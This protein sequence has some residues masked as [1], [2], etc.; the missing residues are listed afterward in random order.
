MYEVSRSLLKQYPDTMLARMAS[1]TWMLVGNVNDNG[2]KKRK[3][4][5]NGNNGHKNGDKDDDDKSNKKGLFIERNGDRFQFCLDYMR[6]GGIIELPQTVSKEALLQ[7]LNYYG[8]HDVDP[9]SIS[10]KG[11]LS[12]FRTGKKRI[13][14]LKKDLEKKIDDAHKMIVEADR[15]R[16]L[17]WLV[18]VMLGKYE[19]DPSLR[20]RIV[21]SD[22]KEV[23]DIAMELPGM[24]GWE[25]QSELNVH[26]EIIGLRC[27]DACNA[28]D[29]KA[30]WLFL[31]FV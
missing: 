21:E 7:D 4:N 24:R 12:M 17:H 3:K 13:L 26:L 19:R 31:E 25:K 16:K 10:V 28:N 2:S 23:Y 29:G 27:T 18:R 11:S 5:E 20:I 6:D 22:G 1:D 30:V 14:S 15:N 9:S 8:F